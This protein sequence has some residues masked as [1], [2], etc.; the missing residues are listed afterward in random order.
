MVHVVLAVLNFVLY[1][2]LFSETTITIGIW[3]LYLQSSLHESS[4][5]VSST[6]PKQDFA[7]MKCIDQRGESEDKT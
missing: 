5:L 2:V 7:M 1:Y 6:Q 4:T 3:W